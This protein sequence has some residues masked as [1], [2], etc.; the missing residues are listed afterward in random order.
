MGT[1][2]YH[3]EGISEDVSETHLLDPIFLPAEDSFKR[4]RNGWIKVHTGRYFAVYRY[5]KI[6][7]G[8]FTA[9]RHIMG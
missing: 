6:S 8:V 9:H 3:R 1:I 5:V 4:G 2:P 7:K